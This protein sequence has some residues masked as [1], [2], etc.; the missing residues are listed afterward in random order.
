MT[1]GDLAR[2]GLV[3]SVRDGAVLLDDHSPAAVAVAHAGSPAVV[4]GEEG[5]GVGEE[6][7]PH[8]STVVRKTSGPTYNRLARSLVHLAPCVHDPGIVGSNDDNKV[9]TLGLELIQLL[10]VGGEV[11]GLAAGS[12]GTYTCSISF[13]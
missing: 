7:L 2:V 9:D 6:V 5:L 10:N 8:V 12:E 11:V 1:Y 3:L 4:L 13:V